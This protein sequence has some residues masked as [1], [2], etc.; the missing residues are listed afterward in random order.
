MIK[1][2]INEPNERREII[3]SPEQKLLDI[4]YTHSID[5]VGRLY[6]NGIALDN[7][8]LEQEIGHLVN[9]DRAVLSVIIK[10]ENA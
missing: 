9:G 7:E 5:T 8:D 6:L 3:V 4:I 2:K 10:A 1:L